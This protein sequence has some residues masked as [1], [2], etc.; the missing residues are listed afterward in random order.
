[1][2]TWISYNISVKKSKKCRRV[3]N[4]RFPT[5]R[6]DYCNL[7]KETR[8]MFGLSHDQFTYVTNKTSSIVNKKIKKETDRYY[9]FYKNDIFF[10][11]KLSLNLLIYHIL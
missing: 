7:I 2:N 3:F 9:F 5:V 10:P 4:Y 6:S 11:A 1:M 8:E